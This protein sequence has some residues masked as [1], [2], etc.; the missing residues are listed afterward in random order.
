MIVYV[1]IIGDNFGPYYHHNKRQLRLPLLSLWRQLQLPLLLIW[2]QIRLLNLYTYHAHAFLIVCSNNIM[3]FTC[4]FQTYHENLLLI[5]IIKTYFK[6]S[7]HN[8][9][10]NIQIILKTYLNIIENIHKHISF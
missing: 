5:K 9:F 10:S 2:R 8:R 3:F 6:T 1:I 7:L 4:S